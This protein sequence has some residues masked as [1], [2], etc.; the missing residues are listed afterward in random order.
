MTPKLIYK[1][2]LKVL[3]KST[4]PN[5]ETPNPKK[6]STT[7]QLHIVSSKIKQLRNG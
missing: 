3:Y 7:F 1:P 4:L 5:L 6:Q 2:N